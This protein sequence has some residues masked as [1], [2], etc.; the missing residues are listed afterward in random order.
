MEGKTVIVTGANSGIGKAT[1]AALVALRA[2]VILACRD[3]S[4][5][6]EAARDIQQQTGADGSL[7]LVK[8]LDLASLDSVRA[9]CRDIMKVKVLV[10]EVRAAEQ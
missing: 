8:Q 9:F 4:R 3:A 2:R 10:L 6:E 1:A 5:A 7:L